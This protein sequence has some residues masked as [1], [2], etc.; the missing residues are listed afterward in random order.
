MTFTTLL[1]FTYFAKSGWL[2]ALLVMAA[3]GSAYFAAIVNHQLILSSDPVKGPYPKG[4]L[5]CLLMRLGPLYLPL[6][7]P[8]FTK[9][10][11]EF[12][13]TIVAEPQPLARVRKCCRIRRM[14]G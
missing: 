5:Q 13:L 10:F 12:D 9:S 11:C 4:T 8:F 1:A 7:D 14:I 3:T 6:T 2:V